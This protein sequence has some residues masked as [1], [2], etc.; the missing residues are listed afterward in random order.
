MSK[1]FTNLRAEMARV[2]ITGRDMAKVLGI[3]E[4]S[5]YNKLNGITEFTLREI[6][7]IRDAYFPNLTIDEL[8]ESDDRQVS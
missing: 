1:K 7:A 3:A 2:S 8:F 5:A 6:V 4:S